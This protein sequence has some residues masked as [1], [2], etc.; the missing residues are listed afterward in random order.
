MI[1]VLVV[2]DH[3]LFREG[4]STLLQSTEDA[5]LIGEATNGEEAIEMAV[6]LRPDVILMD[7]N[8]PKKN[9]IEATRRITK[10]F[11]EIS[12]LVLTMFDDDD[13]VF[14]A[15]KA[16]A[17]GY[18]LK[19]ANRAETIRA[20]QAVANGESIFSP[21]IA[22]RLL[23]FF[24]GFQP[25]PSTIFPQ[26]TERERDIL[27]LIVE[28]KE[29]AEISKKLGIALKTVRNHISNIY[30]KLQVADRAAAIA[31]AKNEGMGRKEY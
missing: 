23:Q 31:Q 28:G 11:P 20:I 4:I 2:D 17:K 24:K 12:V 14:A 30:S 1:K 22:G 7:L 13:S 10:Q 29:N 3:P 26:L 21:A 27:E 16:G 19:G 15:L 18:L 8:L 6:K 5:E 9:G 25:V